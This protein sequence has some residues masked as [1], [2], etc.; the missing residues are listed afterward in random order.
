MSSFP[1][2]K[3]RN[4]LKRLWCGVFYGSSSSSHADAAL[5]VGQ[6]HHFICKKVV[7]VWYAP[8]PSAAV[9][10]ADP[11]RR[12]LLISSI[13]YGVSK[14][15]LVSFVENRLGLEQKKD[16]SL[17]FQPPCANLAFSSERGNVWKEM[18]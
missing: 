11:D 9:A 12:L 4:S 14:E 7:Q 13:P 6:Q 17:D 15:H 3:V 8:D 16:F 1:P 18:E 10:G 5:V 2:E